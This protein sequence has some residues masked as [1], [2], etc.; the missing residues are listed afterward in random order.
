MRY[1]LCPPNININTKRYVTQTYKRLDD[2]ENS[3]KNKKQRPSYDRN[4]QG[5]SQQSKN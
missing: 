4:G 2:N 3:C 1:I 5:N